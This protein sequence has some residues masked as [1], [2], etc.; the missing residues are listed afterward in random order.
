MATDSTGRRT[1]GDFPHFLFPFVPELFNFNQVFMF[2]TKCQNNVVNGYIWFFSQK[3]CVS[4]EKKIS[5]FSEEKKNMKNYSSLDLFLRLGVL[6]YLIHTFFQIWKK[7]YF[8]I[9]I[10]QNQFLKTKKKSKVLLLFTIYYYL[11]K[12][13]SSLHV[14]V[15]KKRKKINEKETLFSTAL[16]V[17]KQLAT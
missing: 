6:I 9:T 7:K 12:N 15:S 5:W 16:C 11:P 3:K 2:R 17:S 4:L 13:V 14:K 1:V 8:A 10:E